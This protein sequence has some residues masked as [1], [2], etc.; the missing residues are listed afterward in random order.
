MVIEATL[1][2]RDPSSVSARRDRMVQLHKDYDERREFWTKSDLEQSLK[3][4]LTKTSDVE[5]PRFWT[6]VEQE[7]LPALEK[8]DTGAA[9]TAYAKLEPAYAAHRIIRHWKPRLPSA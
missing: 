5:V 1:V 8:K 9:E 3:S 4:K 2:L 7:L 6:V